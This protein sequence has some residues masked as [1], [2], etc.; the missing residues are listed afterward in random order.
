MAITIKNEGIR[1]SK[2]IIN[3]V[4]DTT[5]LDSPINIPIKYPIT[6][7]MVKKIIKLSVFFFFVVMFFI[8]YNR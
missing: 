2:T 6:I 8:I 4:L 3:V 1:L 7:L 5:R